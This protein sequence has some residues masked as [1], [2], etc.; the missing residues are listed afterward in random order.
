MM[1]N[2]PAVGAG[3]AEQYNVAN[4]HEGWLGAKEGKPMHVDEYVNAIVVV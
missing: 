4:A 3:A 1:G 2:V